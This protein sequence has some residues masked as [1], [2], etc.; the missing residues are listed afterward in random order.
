[1]RMIFVAADVQRPT[2]HIKQRHDQ[3]HRNRQLSQC[4]LW[5]QPL[6]FIAMDLSEPRAREVSRGELIRGDFES[7]SQ[8]ELRDPERCLRD[9][10][11]VLAAVVE[12]LE[13]PQRYVPKLMQREE[14]DRI[15]D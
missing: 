3:G 1:M 12:K 5:M 6:F 14:V 2:S 9:F 13:M 8:V 4:Q 7:L 15:S 11:P 10:A